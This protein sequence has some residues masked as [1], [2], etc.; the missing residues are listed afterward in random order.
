MDCESLPRMR[1]W[2]LAPWPQ[3]FH[4]CVLMHSERGFS[5]PCV[6]N[7]EKV[8]YSLPSSPKKKKSLQISHGLSHRC[9]SLRHARLLCALR[10][11]LL[12]PLVG[13]R[14]CQTSAPE[15]RLGE[16]AVWVAPSSLERQW[17]RQF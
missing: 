5:R 15:P 9:T 8:C 10:S 12:R 16:S 6:A 13:D 3:V 2:R 1:F 7:G 14:P 17:A 4:K 11:A